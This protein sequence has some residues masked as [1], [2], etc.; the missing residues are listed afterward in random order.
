MPSVRDPRNLAVDGKVDQ[1]V[2]VFAARG[3]GVSGE[4]GADGV[5]ERVA[6][7]AGEEPFRCGGARRAGDQ[8]DSFA[9]VRVDIDGEAGD[10]GQGRGSAE[11]S[12]RAQCEQGAQAVAVAPDRR[13]SSNIG[14]PPQHFGQGGELPWFRIRA[15][16]VDVLAVAQQD[17]RSAHLA[18]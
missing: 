5:V 4:P 1:R 2:V 14:Y 8:T 15:G 18:G 9:Q 13:G 3:G 11:D 10:G 12:G 6:V 7:P 16:G 17:R